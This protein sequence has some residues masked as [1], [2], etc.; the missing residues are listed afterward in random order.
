MFPR[1]KSSKTNSIRK[2]KRIASFPNVLMNQMLNV[3]IPLGLLW[4]R[5]WQMNVG[6]TGMLII[7][8]NCEVDVS[9]VFV[10]INNDNTHSTICYFNKIKCNI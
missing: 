8:M 2:Q 10:E 5:Y 1:K 3:V 4:S 9:S 7:V 6:E